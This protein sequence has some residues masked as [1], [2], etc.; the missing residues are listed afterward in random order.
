VARIGTYVLES[1]LE[2][3]SQM[4]VCELAQYEICMESRVRVVK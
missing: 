4:Q 3:V 1:T 2:G